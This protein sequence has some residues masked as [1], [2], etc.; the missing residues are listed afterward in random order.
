MNHLESTSFIYPLT[1]T[2]MSSIKDLDTFSLRKLYY[3]LSIDMRYIMIE[4]FSGSEYDSRAITKKLSYSALN[5]F[6]IELSEDEILQ[7]F[8][9]P[10]ADHL[11]PL[12]T[13]NF[14]HVQGEY[15][16]SIHHYDFKSTL[17]L[18]ISGLAKI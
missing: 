18:Y 7:I 13:I 17:A 10:L 6:G 14:T 5:N 12:S 1:V 11:D 15:A 2:P 8:V 9:Q 4:E 3:L 16:L